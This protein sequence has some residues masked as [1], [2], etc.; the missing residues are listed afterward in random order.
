MSSN[1]SSDRGDVRS[2]EVG[3]ATSETSV[4]RAEPGVAI[5]GRNRSGL[6]IPATLAGTLTA[7]GALILLAG[8]I[9][10]ALGAIGYQTGLEGARD[11]LSIGGLVAGLVALFV[12]FLIGGWVAARIARHHGGRHGLVTAV[13]MIV[14]AAL[15]AAL[16][17]WFGSE[18]DVFGDLGLPQW[19]SQDA[20]TTAAIVS[21]LAALV[22]MLLG[23]WLGG[24]WGDA[25]HDRTDVELVES[26]HGVVSRP[27]GLAAAPQGDR[28]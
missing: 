8:L 28:R 23:G 24:R 4:Y 18:F 6:N 15:L 25:S 12:A 14:L 3:A 13:W 22:A 1:Y 17:A 9:G 19:F 16:G 27:G 2:D 11:E 10:A 26:R 21:G 5:A 7:I 20:L